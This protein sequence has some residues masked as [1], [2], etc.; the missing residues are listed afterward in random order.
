MSDEK[1]A[2]LSLARSV[3]LR[4]SGLKVEALN[5]NLKARLALLDEDELRVVE[6]IKEKLNRNLAD[7]VK[8]A[9]DT[10]GGFVW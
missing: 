6:Q 5:D 7:A 2:E 8:E 3:R 10:V 4:N 9:A 1:S